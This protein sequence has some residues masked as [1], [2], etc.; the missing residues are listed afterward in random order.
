[1]LKKRL[2]RAELR[3]FFAGLSP[4]LIGME[5]RASA[6]Y[7]ARELAAVGHEVRLMPPSYAKPYVKRQ[8]NDAGLKQTLPLRRELADN[9]M[10][11]FKARMRLSSRML[12]FPRTMGQA[13]VEHIP[14]STL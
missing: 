7:W 6:H 10:G 1:M 13:H 11:R 14:E 3:A 2:R 8:K 4:C 9:E 5:A 12:W